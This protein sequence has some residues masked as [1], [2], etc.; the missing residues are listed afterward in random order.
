MSTIKKQMLFR[1][2]LKPQF[3]EG[4]IQGDFQLLVWSISKEAAVLA[5][6]NAIGGGACQ[7][8]YAIEATAVTNYNVEITRTLTE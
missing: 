5:V 2:Q 7:D 8:L 1:V 4:F 3:N 6:E